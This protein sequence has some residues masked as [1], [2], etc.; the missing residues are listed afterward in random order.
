MSQK[1]VISLS[2][3]MDSTSLL[4]A[5]MRE[6]REFEAVSFSYGSTHNP[7]ENAAAAEIAAFYG[8][9]FH[10]IDL[11]AV[12][13]SFRSALLASNQKKIPEGHY[14]EESMSMTVVPGRNMIFASILAGF[15]WSIKAEEVWLGV[16]SGDHAIYPDCRPGF[17]EAMSHAI[18]E[19]TGGR[20]VLYTPFLHLDKTKIIKQGL[21]H[22]VP[23]HLTRTCYKPQLVSCGKCGA[24]QERLE[25]FRNNETDDPI[26]YESRAALPKEVSS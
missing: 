25:A 26:K 9:P 10:P 6:G 24:C 4:A 3:G 23:Y 1:A 12:M 15:A 14:E 8:I 7:Y 17:V 16:H 20:V 2:G 21:L 13:G 18:Q 11:M 19:G 22:K 5:G